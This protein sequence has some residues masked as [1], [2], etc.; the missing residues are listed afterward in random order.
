MNIDSEASPGGVQPMPAVV[1]EAAAGRPG[2]VVPRPGRAQTIRLGGRV[3]VRSVGELRFRLYSAIDSG[4]GTLRVDVAGLE[5][6]D[7]AGL[8]VLL[9]GARR[10]R[11]QGRSMVLVAVPAALGSL[12]DAHRLGQVLRR[13]EAPELLHVGHA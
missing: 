3:D 6:A 9:G 1:A 2:V 4:S 10:A 8:G 12:L 5:L 11:R 13:E 7:D